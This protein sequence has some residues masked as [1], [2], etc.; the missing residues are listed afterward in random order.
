M[1]FRFDTIKPM[2]N[3]RL[4]NLIERIQ[5]LVES[6]EKN[7]LKT[8]GLQSVH[9][10]ILRYLSVCNKYS[11]TPYALS[12]FLGNTKGTTS[13]SL[14][15][16]ESRGYIIKSKNTKD[17]REVHLDM[18]QKGNELLN[19]VSNAILLEESSETDPEVAER[20]LQQLLHEI[21]RQNDQK[22]F[23]VCKTC[24]HFRTEPKGFRCGLTGE[25]LRTEETELIC[26]EHKEKVL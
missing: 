25:P 16:L 23:G 6:E 21:Q 4:L 11:N 13:Q 2:N 7:I 19:T 15:L 3:R 26:H 18:T 14:K 8:L 24:M 9:L 10:R 22:M 20:I 12:N 17:R 1:L 5:N